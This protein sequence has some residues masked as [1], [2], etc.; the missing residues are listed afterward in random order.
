[1]YGKLTIKVLQY[2]MYRVEY[3]MCVCRCHFKCIVSVLMRFIGIKWDRHSWGKQITCVNESMTLSSDGT[4]V[5]VAT[6]NHG[7]GS[8]CQKSVSM[9]RPVLTGNKFVRI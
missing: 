6:P 8:P 2:M 9:S 3:N 1:V 4:V 7:G 5:A